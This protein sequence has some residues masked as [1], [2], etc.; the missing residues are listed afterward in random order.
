MRLMTHQR[1]SMHLA[2]IG[3]KRRRH[4]ETSASAS[5]DA[6]SDG[7]VSNGSNGRDASNSSAALSALSSASACSESFSAV[8]NASVSSASSVPSVASSCVALRTHRPLECRGVRKRDTAHGARNAVMAAEDARLKQ[9]RDVY[10]ASLT[11]EQLEAERIK[12]ANKRP[13]R[14]LVLCKDGSFQLWMTCVRCGVD[15]QLVHSNF[16]LQTFCKS[17]FR[18]AG[19]ESFNNSMSSP[20]RECWKSV[21]VDYNSLVQSRI[22]K[23]MSNYPHVSFRS[24]P[25]V[26][27]LA[28]PSPSSGRPYKPV[29][30]GL[31]WFAAQWLAQGGTGV[32]ITPPRSAHI[33][34]QPYWVPLTSAR[35]ALY[36]VPLVVNDKLLSPSVN[37]FNVARGCDSKEHRAD[38]CALVCTFSNVSQ[39]EAIPDLRAACAD[40]VRGTL[41][42]LEAREVRGA[43][44]FGEREDKDTEEEA[45]FMAGL[46]CNRYFKKRIGHMA[47]R[48]RHSDTQAGRDNDLKTKKALLE[49]LRAHGPRC[50]ITHMLFT[51]DSSPFFPSCDRIDNAKGHVRSNVRWVARL[52]CGNVNPTRAEWLRII[53]LQQTLVP[54]T[55]RQRELV[56]RELLAIERV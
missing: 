35:C 17:A 50:D 48:N 36:G 56:E 19:H 25:F 31:P 53:V 42:V 55:P 34:S 37:N 12:L 33:N 10:F 22:R 38:E 15:K 5:S 46:G 3:L 43:Q 11:P 51:T 21:A 27:Q 45:V 8:P 49:C 44:S 41:A 23:L 39:H 47:K 1:S 4:D 30:N 26:F 7:D 20:C 32:W 14:R 29:A 13:P 16:K 9:A 24:A 40:A 6:S 28:E 18:R 52:F 54:L 2:R